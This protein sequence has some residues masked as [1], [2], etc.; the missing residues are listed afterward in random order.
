MFFDMASQNAWLGTTNDEITKNLLSKYNI[1]YPQVLS[2]LFATNMYLYNI[3][4]SCVMT[5]SNDIFNL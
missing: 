2:M 4:K 3:T 1:V 5:K